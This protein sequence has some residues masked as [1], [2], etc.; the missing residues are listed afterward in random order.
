MGM[1]QILE[2]GLKNLL[3]RRYGYVHEKMEKWT[4][5][6]V[7]TELEKSGLRS[8]FIA[9]L[10]SVVDYRNNIA[11]EYLANEALLKAILGG[12]T[13]RLN[14]EHFDKAVYELE[15]LIFLYDWCEGHNAWA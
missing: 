12:D 13:V 11:H 6:M 10:T 1:A 2:A 4:L 3:V 14:R 5:G 7:K 15:Q 8:N 9:L